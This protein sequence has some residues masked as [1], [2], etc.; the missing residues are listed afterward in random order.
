MVQSSGKTLMR[1][2]WMALWTAWWLCDA[3]LDQLIKRGTSGTQWNWH[4]HNSYQAISRQTKRWHVTNVMSVK[5]ALNIH[6]YLLQTCQKQRHALCCFGNTSETCGGVA[7][8]QP[9][10]QVEWLFK[11]YRPCRRP[12]MRKQS[13]GMSNAFCLYIFHPHFPKIQ[14]SRGYVNS[15]IWRDAFCLFMDIWCYFFKVFCIERFNDARDHG[16]ARKV[17]RPGHVAFGT[18]Q[19]KQK[20]KLPPA[21]KLRRVGLITAPCPNSGNVQV[22]S[23][24]ENLCAT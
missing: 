11:G 18:H 22:A 6:I 19:K 14:M 21:K 3:T 15:I 17:K 4:W 13:R 10:D 12:L 7:L 24:K 23:N 2:S 9:T 20:K 1:A 8:L 5:C 16:M